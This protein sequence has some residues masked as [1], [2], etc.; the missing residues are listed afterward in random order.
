MLDIFEEFLRHR[1]GAGYLVPTSG[2]NVRLFWK[3]DDNF[4]EIFSY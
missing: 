1:P 2:R 3:G 4:S